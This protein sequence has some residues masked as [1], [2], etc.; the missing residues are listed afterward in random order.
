MGSQLCHGTV[1]LPGPV[2]PSPCSSASRMLHT[3]VHACARAVQA[4]AAVHL[5]TGFPATGSWEGQE[6]SGTEWI[7]PERNLNR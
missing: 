4:C 6:L 7:N 2:L 1:G 3:I 5:L